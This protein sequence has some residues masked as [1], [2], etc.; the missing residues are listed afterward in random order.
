VRALLVH[1]RDPR[2]VR[3]GALDQL[4]GHLAASDLTRSAPLIAPPGR[5]AADSSSPDPGLVKASRAQT[6]RQ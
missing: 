2:P 4:D 6:A 5:I 3:R 1:D